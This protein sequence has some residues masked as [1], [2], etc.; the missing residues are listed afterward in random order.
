MNR[1]GALALA[2][3]VWAC[4]TDVRQA[5][6]LTPINIEAVDQAKPFALRGIEFAIRRG[7]DV[8]GH[9]IGLTC[10][11]S[12]QRLTWERGRFAGNN[13]WNDRFFEELNELGYP[14]VGDPAR[15]FERD[16]DVARAAYS[17]SAQVAA[18]ELSVCDQRNFWTGGPM[19]YSGKAWVKVRW[20]VY[21]NLT[22]RVVLETETEGT[23]ITEQ[24][25]FD[26]LIIMGQEAFAAATRNLAG[27]P[28]FHVIASGQSD[29]QAADAK[30]DTPSI[31]LTG[32][33]DFRG[34]I[35]GRMNLIRVSTPTIDLGSGHGSGF[36]VTADGY[37]LTNDHVVGDRKQVTVRLPGGAE[38]IGEVLKTD[39]VRDIA[40]VKVAIARTPALPVRR[41]PVTVGEE[42]YAIGTP[43]ET[44]LSQTVTRGIVSAMRTKEIGGG[45]AS[46]PLIQSDV[47][48]QNGNSGGPLVDAS[49]NVVAV[50]VS[51]FGELNSGTNFFIPIGDALERLGI[52][53]V[54]GAAQANR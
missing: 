37:L 28:Q 49:G 29:V 1:L 30:S 19:G 9:T 6:K 53:I 46:I 54:P 44:R 24:S 8:G 48:I 36:F 27:L 20:Q 22:R 40:L 32:V 7:Q 50:C 16:R 3:L 31:E 17:I 43:L 41:T 18:I 26:G 45:Q 15:P 23:G 39:R 13:E 47:V 52:S 35:Q 51:G 11:M 14:V 5:P 21:S 2:L 33:P 25:T 10:I 12:P 38:V 42:V 34:P 4:Q